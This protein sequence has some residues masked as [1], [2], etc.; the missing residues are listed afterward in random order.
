MVYLM[1]SLCVTT[2]IFVWIKMCCAHKVLCGS[3]RDH[4]STCH[5]TAALLLRDTAAAE[6]GGS[7]GHDEH[8]VSVV[9]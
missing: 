9:F 3:I 5:M 8:A 4:V 2:R 7:R 6:L 1:F